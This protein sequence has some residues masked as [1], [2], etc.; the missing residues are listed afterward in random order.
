[1]NMCYFDAHGI[2]E[3]CVEAVRSFGIPGDVKEA[4]ETE[5]GKVQ[6]P[7]STIKGVLK[8]LEDGASADSLRDLLLNISR[9][10]AAAAGHLMNAIS[11]E[12]DKSLAELMPRLE[13]AARACSD[14]KLE[15]SVYFPG[16]VL[17]LGVNRAF[18]DSKMQSLSSAQLCR[19]R[20]YQVAWMF[21][22]LLRY[23][24]PDYKSRGEIHIGGS[25]ACDFLMEKIASWSGVS[26]VQHSK[27]DNPG[28]RG[29]HVFAS[30]AH[31]SRFLGFDES[32]E[33]V[34]RFIDSLPRH[35]Q[36]T[37]FEAEEG[38]EEDFKL[39]EE[40]FSALLPKG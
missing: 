20:F 31:R 16:P 26:I 12:A 18:G 6:D 19:L 9:P 39:W 10:V 22:R 37:V 29:A 24:D 5:L 36:P 27:C 1:M 8:Q 23:T 13:G 11:K 25:L 38:G 40:R 15:A 30:L 32:R 14:G 21:V 3:P 7:T 17:W 35:E 4:V 34:I 2:L 28:L 33:G